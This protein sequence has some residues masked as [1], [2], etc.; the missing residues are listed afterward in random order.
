VTRA[1]YNEHNKWKAQALR[2]LMAAGLIAPGDIDE[3][4]IEDVRPDDLRGYTQ[5]HFFAGIGVWSRALRLAGW[6]DERAIWTGS[7]PCQ[8]FS[9]AGKGAGFDDERHLWPAWHWLIQ[10]RRPVAVIGEQ[11]ASS[12]AAPWLDLVHADLEGLGFTVGALAF[13]AAGIGAPHIRDRAYWCGVLGLADADNARLEGWQILPERTDQLAAGAHGLARSVADADRDRYEA[14]RETPAPLGYRGSAYTESWPS[15]YNVHGAV[16]GFWRDADWLPCS[17]DK[18]RPVEP[19]SFPLVD[20]PTAAMGRL[21]AYG[22][23]IVEPAARA[24]I[25]C[26]IEAIGDLL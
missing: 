25:G 5:C 13:P 23:A 17:D 16:N 20:G 6:D 10:E 12:D 4:S 15:G 7:C 8:P 18:W 1:Y 14:W 21:H 22:D 9:A 11:V 19:T 26:V 3:R 24:F 2:N